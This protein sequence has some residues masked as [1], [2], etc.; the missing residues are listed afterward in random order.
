YARGEFGAARCRVLRGTQGVGKTAEIMNGFRL[1]P[2]GDTEPGRHRVCGEDENGLRK[3]ITFA[4][5]GSKTAP[6]AA[7]DRVFDGI[8]WRTVADEK[9]R[10][11]R[12]LAHVDRKLCGTA[13]IRL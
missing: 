5:A 1:R 9:C 3:R 11:V 6:C 7:P 2:G 8:R 13:I 4:R 10:H 12:D